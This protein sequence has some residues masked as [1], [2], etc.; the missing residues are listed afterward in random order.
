MKDFALYC[1]TWLHPECNTKTEKLSG[2]GV[3]SLGELC[4]FFTCPKCGQEICCRVPLDQIIADIPNSKIGQL[5]AEDLKLLKEMN[6][7]AKP[8]I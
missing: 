2:I 8:P 5:T 3:N 1:Y 6:I 7:S 4:V